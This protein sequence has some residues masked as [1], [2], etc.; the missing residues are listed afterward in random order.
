M[1]RTFN[2]ADL[3]EIVADTVPDRDAIVA[4]ERRI[5]YRELDQRATRLA[6]AMRAHGVQRGQT[7]G[8]DLYNSIEFMESYFACCK[9]G[10]V[11]VNLNYRYVPDELAYVADTLDISVLIYTSEVDKVVQAVLPRTPKVREIWCVRSSAVE[12]LPSGA[13][14]YET[15]LASGQTVLEDPERSG[16]DLY[17]L[18]TGGTTGMPKGVMWPHRAMFRAALGGG[19][20]FT[21]TGPIATPEQLADNVRATPHMSYVVIAPLMHGGGLWSCLIS[22]FAGSTVVLNE[23]AR[24]DPEYI[25]DLVSRERVMVM[26]LIGDAMALPL[27][28]TL[29]RHPGRWDLTQLKICGNGGAVFST[30]LQ[31]RLQQLVPGLIINNSMG[32]SESGAIQ[33]A[34]PTVH[35][36]GFMRYAP[37]PD[38]AVID[39]HMQPVTAPGA[40]GVLAR[41]GDTP[42][43]YYGDAKK[44]AET[45]VKV[46]GQLWALTGDRVRIDADGY[47][48]V[49]GRGNL[50]INSG[51]EKIFPEEVEEA[52]RR[53]PAVRDA[54][55]TWSSRSSAA[56]LARPITA[57]P[58]RWH[59]SRL[60]WC[61]AFEA[62][63]RPRP[64]GWPTR[65][66]G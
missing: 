53:Y 40:E 9:I 58:S 8:I 31:E 38:L 29:E 17:I 54:Q 26:A 16:E 1:P 15:V 46:Q 3:F 37:R 62:P 10:A 6:S 64:D 36:E 56:R 19:G 42:V 63:G 27:I 59:W 55:F 50:C 18:C 4:G 13:Q 33:G 61:D 47:Y 41:T 45:F 14:D 11:P 25:W 22:L 51:G 2:L 65:C 49:L 34:V 66:P 39:H 60:A 24:F 43:G 28:Q 7:V 23:R 30:H 48:A 32:S 52:I 5:T 35:G 12:P 44:T 20:F 57:G 21:R